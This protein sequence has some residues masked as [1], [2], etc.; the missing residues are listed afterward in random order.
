M[1]IT[2]VALALLI[3]AQ[4]YA[5]TADRERLCKNVM[6]AA[7]MQPTSSGNF[8]ESLYKAQ[9]AYANCMA[10]V[11]QPLP[12]QRRTICQLTSDGQSIVCFEQ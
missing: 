2:L 4:A 12:Q 8:S 3:P 1:R 11:Q 6:A 7:L 10:G 5:Q 9:V